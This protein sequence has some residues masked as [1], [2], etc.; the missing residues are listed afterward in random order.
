MHHL[1]IPSGQSDLAGSSGSIPAQLKLTQTPSVMQIGNQRANEN[2][3][4][5]NAEPKDAE[6]AAAAADSLGHRPP[7]SQQHHHVDEIRNSS[8]KDSI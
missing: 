5:G 7:S 8:D 6:I 1:N 3:D 4:I 2:S